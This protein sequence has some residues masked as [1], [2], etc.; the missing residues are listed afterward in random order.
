MRTVLVLEDDYRKE[1]LVFRHKKDVSIARETRKDHMEWMDGDG[2]RIEQRAYIVIRFPSSKHAD[3]SKWTRSGQDNWQI[4]FK[5]SEVDG[6]TELLFYDQFTFTWI[7]SLLE[8]MGIAKVAHLSYP[9]RKEGYFLPVYVDAHGFWQL[10]YNL[11]TLLIQ[12]PFIIHAERRY[13]KEQRE[14]EQEKRGVLHDQ[15]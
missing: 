14:K 15:I 7:A 9:G 13:L 8:D 4:G 2:N 11:V 10:P 5:R 1:K 6:M 3:W 12:S